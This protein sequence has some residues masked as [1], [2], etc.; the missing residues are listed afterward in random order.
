[1]I[2]PAQHARTKG[3]SRLLV[4]YFAASVPL[5]PA[6]HMSKRARN[7]TAAVVALAVAIPAVLEWA[8]VV[9]PSFVFSDGKMIVLPTIAALRETPTRLVFLVFTLG[10]AIV[11][12]FY[13][14]QYQDGLLPAQE[15]ELTLAWHLRQFLSREAQGIIGSTEQG[16]T[17]NVR[18]RSLR[19]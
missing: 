19:A 14:G 18:E 2:M 3:H 5:F 11:P 17:R 12:R 15:R 1:M 4:P 10:I 7:V 13:I 8:G 6:F 9:S 16:R